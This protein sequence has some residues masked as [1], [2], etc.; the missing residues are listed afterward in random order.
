MQIY[1][2]T[3]AKHI[4]AIC[5][6]K[7]SGKDTVA[8]FIQSNYNYKHFKIAHCLKHVCKYLFDFTDDDM[9]SDT[10]DIVNEKWGVTPR[11]VLQFI[12]TELMQYRLQELMPGI[13]RDFW[14]RKCI[15]QIESTDD[16]IV[17]SDLRFI[18]EY[19]A[20]KRMYGDRL[21]VVKILKTIEKKDDHES[22][23]EWERIHADYAVQNDSELEQLYMNVNIFMKFFR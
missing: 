2:K 7:R 5:G 21:C 20:L 9:E 17:I 18:H 14:I 10:K 8:N 16:N 13:G 11:K 12:G 3:M 19:E 6:Y 23:T 1:Q 22:E 15:Q 4:I